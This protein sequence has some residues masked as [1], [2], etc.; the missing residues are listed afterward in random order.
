MIQAA[1][2]MCELVNDPEI[3]G[4]EF[5]TMP[6]ETPKSASAWWKRRAAR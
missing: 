2:R 1:E 6:T 5:R 4:Q 3:T